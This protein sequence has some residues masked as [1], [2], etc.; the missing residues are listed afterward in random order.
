MNTQKYSHVN[1][2]L[3]YK[4]GAGRKIPFLYMELILGPVNL[5]FPLM[6][7]PGRKEEGI[8]PPPLV[9]GEGGNTSLGDFPISPT[10]PP[11]HV[12]W[13]AVDP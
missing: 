12:P 1:L 10:P 3:K 5:N 11:S 2:N 4:E 9:G 8:Y 7:R 6:P 13:P